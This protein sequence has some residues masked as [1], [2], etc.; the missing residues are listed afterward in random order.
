MSRSTSGSVLAGSPTGPPI[1]SGR[2]AAP[3]MAA[4]RSI[5]CGTQ[6]D[7]ART[8]G[9]AESCPKILSDLDVGA[10]IA[11]EHQL[12]GGGHERAV[13]DLPGVCL[14]VRTA[15]ADEV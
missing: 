1:D 4:S 8:G 6:V 3:V 13:G 14:P 5:E 11:V 15:H 9:P 7:R 2:C 12:A 10:W